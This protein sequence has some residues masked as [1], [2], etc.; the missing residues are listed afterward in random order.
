MV[1]GLRVYV[2]GFSYGVYEGSVFKSGY[3]SSDKSSNIIRILNK[4]KV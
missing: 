1:Y 2:L 3:M 4:Q